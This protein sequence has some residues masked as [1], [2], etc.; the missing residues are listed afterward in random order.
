VVPSHPT[1][2]RPGP[3]N[4]SRS[5]PIITRSKNN[6]FKPKQVFTT[7][8]HEIPENIEPSTVTQALKIPEW[9]QACSGEFDAL[10]HNR[11]WSLVPRTNNQNIA[12]CKWLFRVKRN[13]DG[14]VSRYKARLVAKGF[15]QTPGIDFKETFSPVVKPQTIKF[16]LIIALARRWPMHQLDVNNAFLQGKL[17]KDVYTQ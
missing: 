13:L 9:I 6:I 12:D 14:S 17:T 16:V 15:T 11:T 10:P 1:T 2:T 4:H 7:T 8:K 3:T 5:E